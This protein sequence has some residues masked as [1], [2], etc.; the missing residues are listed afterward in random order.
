MSRLEQ[1]IRKKHKRPTGRRLKPTH[2]NIYNI[3]SVIIN[4]N[5]HEYV[6]L[7]DRMDNIILFI[8]GGD[9]YEEPAFVRSLNERRAQGF[10]G[11][12]V[13]LAGNCMLN[14]KS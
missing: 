6:Y 8:V 5:K 11:P 10:G 7:S 9:T 1:R 14:T 4:K 2:C 3:R 12:A 13:V